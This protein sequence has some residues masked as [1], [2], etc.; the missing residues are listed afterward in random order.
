M[1]AIKLTFTIRP[2]QW[3]KNTTLAGAA[4]IV[5]IVPARISTTRIED[6]DKFISPINV[7]KSKHVQIVK[8]EITERAD[9]HDSEAVHNL[10]LTIVE[11]AMKA[12]YD[13]LFILAIIDAESNFNVEAVSST[14]A[15][16]LMQL[17]PSTF[18][19]VSNA[20]RMFDPIEN[21]KAGIRYLATLSRFKHIDKILL[22][23]NQGP[24]AVI[25]VRN[26]AE[27]PDEGL[28]YIPRVIGKYK[29]ILERYGRNPKMANK[30][31][32]VNEYAVAI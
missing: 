7:Y 15:R 12:G 21:V 24:G 18:K 31:F 29:N 3:F 10:A 32:R 11:E 26:G 25:N 30:L 23:Y 2:Y 4:V 9:I 17:M 6:R 14:G 27:T 22:A 19:S 1:K 20:R 16:G 13:P 28:A 5:L 8:V